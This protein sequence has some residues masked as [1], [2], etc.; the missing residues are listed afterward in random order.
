[1]DTDK[2]MKEEIMDSWIRTGVAGN[3]Q[4]RFVGKTRHSIKHKTSMQTLT[5][6]LQAGTDQDF[7]VSIP[8]HGVTVS[9]ID[10]M[11]AMLNRAKTFQI[12]EYA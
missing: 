12:A 8:I 3:T 10:E 9:D 4:I 1:M 11:I 7:S 6:Q 2:D 5:I